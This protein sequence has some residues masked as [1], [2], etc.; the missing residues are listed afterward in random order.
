MPTGAAS[1]IE[2][3]VFPVAKE[4]A[5]DT[6]VI[7]FAEGSSGIVEGMLEMDVGEA[8]PDAIRGG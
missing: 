6:T 7:R 1:V 3:S 5:C 8:A 4:N 2:T